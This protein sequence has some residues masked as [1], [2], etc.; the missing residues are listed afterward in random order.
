MDVIEIKENP[1]EGV[2][3]LQPRKYK[4]FSRLIVLAIALAMI[5]SSVGYAFMF[6]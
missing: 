3:T 5:L 6:F 4:N 2:N 1:L